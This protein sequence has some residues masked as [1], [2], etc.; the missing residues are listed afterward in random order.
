VKTVTMGI[1]DG[2]KTEILS[3]AIQAGEQVIIGEE[4]ARQ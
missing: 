2:S 4:T 3:G 1:S